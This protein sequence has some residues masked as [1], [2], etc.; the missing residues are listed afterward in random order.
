MKFNKTAWQK[1][2][3]ELPYFHGELHSYVRGHREEYL[4]TMVP[5]NVED[6]RGRIPAKNWADYESVPDEIKKECL[7]FWSEHLSPDVLKWFVEQELV[8][9]NRA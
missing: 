4:A 7:D 6:H 2:K 1:I 9:K 5:L 8:V 3:S